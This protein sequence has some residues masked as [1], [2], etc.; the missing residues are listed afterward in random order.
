MQLTHSFQTLAVLP[1]YIENQADLQ[2]TPEGWIILVDKAYTR[3][4]LQINLRLAVFFQILQNTKY[5]FARF[6]LFTR[7]FSVG[8]NSFLIKIS[9]PL[10]CLF[11]ISSLRKGSQVIS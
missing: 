11:S 7:D 5:D 1:T 4:I 6:P 9:E 3:D 8:N 10:C 2:K